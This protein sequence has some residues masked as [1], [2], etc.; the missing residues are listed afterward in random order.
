MPATCAVGQKRPGLTR[1]LL[2]DADT[3]VSGSGM[4]TTA[5]QPSAGQQGKTDAVQNATTAVGTGN[6]VLCLVHR[7]FADDAARSVGTERPRNPAAG[8]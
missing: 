5:V 4:F 1:V 6:D 8:A 7:V 2:P 3:G